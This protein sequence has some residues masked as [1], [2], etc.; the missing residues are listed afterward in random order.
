MYLLDHIFLGMFV[1]LHEVGT[2]LLFYRIV[3]CL[4]VGACSHNVNTALFTLN[5]IV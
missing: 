2:E 3:L 1:V 4:H 5:H